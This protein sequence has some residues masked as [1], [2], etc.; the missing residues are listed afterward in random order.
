MRLSSCLYQYFNEYLPRVKGTSIQS[1]KSY[2]QTFSL[3]L[4]FLADYHSIKVKSLKIE[5][6][7][8]DA[9]LS[10]LYH[11]ET[12]RKNT[13]Q[14]RNNRLAVI[15]SL[16]KMIRFMYPDKKHIG[17]VILNIPQKRAQKKLMGFLYPKEVMKVFN[18]VDLKKKEG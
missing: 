11:L 16:A 4:H 7:S 9:V 6:L 1:I 3:L 18:A 8:A 13:V 17:E 12:H 2:R 10:F 15:K 14:T 5:H